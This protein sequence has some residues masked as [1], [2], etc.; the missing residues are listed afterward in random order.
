MGGWGGGG[1]LDPPEF[2]LL[3]AEKKYYVEPPTP[4]VWGLWI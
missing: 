4:D 3:G 1:A 2:V